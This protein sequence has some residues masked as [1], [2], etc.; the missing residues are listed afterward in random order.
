VR[1]PE[2]RFVIEMP[3]I[4][5]SDG[6][7]RGVVAEGA[8]GAR[9]AGRFRLFRYE[10]RRWRDRVDPRP[11]RGVSSRSTRRP[12]DEPQAGAPAS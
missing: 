3:P 4:R 2:G 10:V 8:V 11:R 6:A 9:A 5:P 1:V 7:E 12:A